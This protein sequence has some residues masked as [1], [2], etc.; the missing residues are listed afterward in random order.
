VS[1]RIA[2]AAVPALKDALTNIYWF[3]RDLRGFLGTAI[4]EPS[5]LAGLNWG[6]IK[7]SVVSDLVDRM[8]RDEHRYREDLV[9]LMVEVG[10]MH[11]FSHLARLED[12]PEK[13]ERAKRAV[14]QLRRYTQPYEQMVAEQAELRGRL[15]AAKRAAER[16]RAVSETLEELKVKVMD[17]VSTDDAQAR[18]YAL[19]DIVRELFELFDLAPKAS[20]AIVGEQ[21][22]GAFHF[23]TEFLFE[24]RW[25]RDPAESNDLDRFAAKIGRKLENTLGLFLSING[26]QPSAIAAHSQAQPVMILMDGADLWAVVDG[27]IELPELL[28]RKRRHAATTG[29]IFFPAARILG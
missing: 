17:L 1:K 5:L 19:Q 29:E 13:V 25:R 26:F 16:S 12:G 27:R 24:A 9:T 28:R 8:V 20:F 2:P 6:D 7:R 22:D 11:D 21:I 18:G 10:R 23:E 15:G 3:K 4:R 14:E